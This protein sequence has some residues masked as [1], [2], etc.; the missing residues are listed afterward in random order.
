[1]DFLFTD[2][3]IG[4]INTLKMNILLTGTD[5]DIQSIYSQIPNKKISIIERTSP[6]LTY[7]SSNK[8]I[9]TNSKILPKQ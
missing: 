5:D 4:T 9:K 1:M 2:N 6:P 7:I 3:N 8:N